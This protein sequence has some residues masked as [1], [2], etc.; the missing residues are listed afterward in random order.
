MI[1]KTFIICDAYEAG[2]GK[3]MDKRE[4]NNPY[5]EGT[6]ANEAWTI[7][8]TL[9]YKRRLESER[10]KQPESTADPCPGCSAPGVCRT[11]AC[12][13]LKLPENHPLRAKT[14]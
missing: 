11:P 10:D 5:K 3:G 6:E 8:Y 2:Y 4:C 12:G 1:S 7:G 14:S 9:G 13:R